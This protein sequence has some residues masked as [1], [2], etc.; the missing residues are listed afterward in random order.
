MTVEYQIIFWRDIPAQVKVRAGGKRLA[1]S[2]TERFQQA[3]D[4]AAMDT[5][6]AGTDAY[7]AE[8]RSSPWNRRNGELELVADGVVSEIESEFPPDRLSCL[9]QT[10]GRNEKT[11]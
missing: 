11:G 3:I 5:G 10:G 9:V 4:Q 8:W 2:L 1:R 6:L 7:L